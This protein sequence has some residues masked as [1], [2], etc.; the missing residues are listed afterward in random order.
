MCAYIETFM[1]S[2]TTVFY[3]ERRG[4]GL[5]RRRRRAL[6]GA[7]ATSYC[8]HL[9]F[10]ERINEQKCTSILNTNVD[11]VWIKRRFFRHPPKGSAVNSKETTQYTF[12]AVSI[13]HER[14][15]QKCS[16]Y[17]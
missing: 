11:D 9:C 15:K 1:S 2:T 8:E 4:G 16:D 7:I 13:A 3:Y 6:S 10:N 14:T 17:E 12:N 5:L